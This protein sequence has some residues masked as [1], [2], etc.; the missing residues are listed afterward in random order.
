MRDFKLNLGELERVHDDVAGRLAP[1]EDSVHESRGQLEDFETKFKN[2]LGEHVE[3][4]ASQVQ[5]EKSSREETEEA[6]LQMLKD[7]VGHI[8]ADLE[9]ERKD[10]ESTEETLLNLLEDTC[11][12]LTQV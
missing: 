12:K 10:R 4:M 7:V 2:Q 11:S 1:L 9:A 6:L 8:K 5:V 3:R